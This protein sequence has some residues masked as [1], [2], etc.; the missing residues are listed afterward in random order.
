VAAIFATRLFPLNMRIENTFPEISLPGTAANVAHKAP[1]AARASAASELPD[2]IG[3]AHQQDFSSIQFAI[4]NDSST[5]QIVV[6]MVDQTTGEV[7]R[8]IPAEEILRTARAIA[9][10][11]AAQQNRARTRG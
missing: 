4:E 1:P 8:Q 10:M 6:K 7:V 2:V 3:S 5:H 9:E 11:M